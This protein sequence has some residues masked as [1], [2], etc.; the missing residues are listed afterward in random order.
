VSYPVFAVPPRQ[1]EASASGASG[2]ESPISWAPIETSGEVVEG[3]ATILLSSL[4]GGRVD[5]SHPVL[6]T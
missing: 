2:H 1:V 5:D 3:L 6:S 4:G